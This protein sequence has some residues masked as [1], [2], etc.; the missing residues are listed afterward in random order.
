MSTSAFCKQQGVHAIS[1]EEGRGVK[2]YSMRATTV[3]VV[4]EEDWRSRVQF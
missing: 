3:V 1:S 4:R 2:L